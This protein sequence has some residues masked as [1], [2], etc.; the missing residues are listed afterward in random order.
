[1]YHTL[2]KSNNWALPGTVHRLM[3]REWHRYNAIKYGVK[4]FRLQGPGGQAQF[5]R[6]GSS[7]RALAWKE[8]RTGVPYIDACMR[9]L[10]QTGWLPYHKRKTVACFLCHDLEV[11]WRLGAFHFEEVLLD[12]DVAMNYGNWI[13][14]ARVDKT[15]DS[16]YAA[17]GWRDREHSAVR[18]SLSV[19]S[20]N[21]PQGLYIRQWVPELRSVPEKHLH[22]PWMMPIEEQQ[23]GASCIIGKDYPE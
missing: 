3:W 18:K 4:L 13:F 19:N 8:G 1:M 7:Q 23:D 16:K 21:D 20:A 9:E 2:L 11:D 12:Y 22:F 5:P 14:C 10:N 17:Q 6:C 15:Y